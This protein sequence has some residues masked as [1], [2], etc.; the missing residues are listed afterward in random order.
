MYDSGYDRINLA[1][2]Y[3]SVRVPICHLGGWNDIFVQGQ[4]NA[5]KNIQQVGRDMARG[6]QKLI[7]GPWV[8]DLTDQT[9]G[10]LTFPKASIYNFFPLMIHWFDYWLRDIDNEVARMENVQVYL[11]G[12]A[13]LT[14]GP[15][16]R[17]VESNEWPP[18][19]NKIPFYLHENGILSLQVPSDDELP[20]TYIYDPTKPVPTLGGRNMNI[21]NGPNDQSEIESR[22][23]VLVYTSEPLEDSLTIVGEVTVSLYAASDAIDTD[24][25]AKICDVYPDGRSM[26]IADGIIRARHRNSITQE[27]FITPG[28]VYLYTIDLWSI[29]IVLAPQHSIR[30][31][32]SS[33][34]Y[35]RFEK[36]LNT[37][38]PFRKDTTNYFI[39]HQTIYHNIQYPSTLNL[40]IVNGLNTEILIA[41]SDLPKTASLGTNF[42]NP[43]N[44][45]TRIAL[46]FKNVLYH[47]TCDLEIFDVKG[48]LL[49]K[50]SFSIFGTDQIL[51]DW[52]GSDQEGTV[53]PTGIYLYRLTMSRFVETRKMTLLR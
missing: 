12:S 34:N 25:T 28:E 7:I 38:N 30:V 32:I 35:P 18:E 17:W 33:S 50:W 10:Q 41:E 24:F 31:S 37:G 29:G 47:E 46:Y 4:I 16:N 39:A 20:D 13:D 8:H 14:E 42:P 52:N 36:N 43:F 53:L 44:S 6:N 22:S 45:K 27:E 23:D 5:F 26:L 1:S 11:M 21:S 9:I 51:V 40:P 2:R 19:S 49:K 48:R 15:G 3:D